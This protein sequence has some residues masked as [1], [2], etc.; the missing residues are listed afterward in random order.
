MDIAQ[1][2]LD[3]A[4][5]KHLHDIGKTCSPSECLYDYNCRGCVT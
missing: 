1:G 3:L 5:A 2:R 4:M